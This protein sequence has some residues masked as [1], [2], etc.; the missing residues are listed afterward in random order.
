VVYTEAPF[1]A[2]DYLAFLKRVAGNHFFYPQA[3]L[4][5]FASNSP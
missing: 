5:I 4:Q 2:E 3:V 1:G